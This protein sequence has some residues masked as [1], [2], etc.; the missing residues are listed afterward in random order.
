MAENL[1]EKRLEEFLRASPQAS[2]EE[3]SAFRDLV[4]GYFT[5]T[6]SP[7]KCTAQRLQMETDFSLGGMGPDEC[8]S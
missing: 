3:I 5:G 6:V 7:E 8:A 4:E 1:A 2:Q